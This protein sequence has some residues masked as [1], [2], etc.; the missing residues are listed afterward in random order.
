MIGDKPQIVSVAESDSEGATF[1]VERE[2]GDSG[3][4]G[5]TPEIADWVSAGN[6][7]APYAAPPNM[8]RANRLDYVND[9]LLDKV[10]ALNDPLTGK[11]VSSAA[12]RSRKYRDTERAQGR[13]LRFLNQAN[14]APNKVN[15]IRSTFAAVDSLEAAAEAIAADIV[16]AADNAIPQ[17]SEIASDIRW[18]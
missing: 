9:L 15:E 10:A 2:N 17:E 3:W 5:M 16:A 8:V 14:P 6:V 18:G 11:P 12:S 4:S 13:A 1:L 7:I